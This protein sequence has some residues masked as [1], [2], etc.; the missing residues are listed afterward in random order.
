MRYS[1]YEQSSHGM[2]KMRSEL[3]AG[4]PAL[5]GYFRSRLLLLSVLLLLVVC[6][7]RATS[8][9]QETDTGEKI[10]IV[11]V[12]RA[13]VTGR[14]IHLGDIASIKSASGSLLEEARNAQ[15]C[16]ASEP[17]FSKTLH[18]GYIKSRLRQ[19][20][21]PD[22]YIS[23]SGA[24]QVI[25][26]TKATRLTPQKILSHAEVSL[27]FW[28]NTRCSIPGVSVHIQPV[29]EI[30]SVTLPYGE[31]TVEVQPVS[32]NS[33]GGI[34][35]LSFAISVDDRECEKRVILFKVEILKEVVIAVRNLDKNKAIESEDLRIALRNIGEHLDVFFQKDE[36]IGK[37]SR[38]PI[39]EGTV[40][41]GNMIEALPVV[42]Q[43]DLVTIVI[44][45]PAFRITAQGKAKEDGAPGQIIRVANISSMKEIPAQVVGEKLVKVAFLSGSM[46]L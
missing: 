16:R 12:E 9:L 23:W 8:G 4:M 41:T 27:K 14:E 17:G 31:V 2:M 1:Y 34:V 19:Q 25:V 45:S 28:I 35:P 7:P 5:P 43:G 39:P 36:L 29:N 18:V 24:Q 40:I 30:R 38:R 46:G 37:R 15:I 20:G 22:E 13:L 10:S 6:A 44:E 21:I 32:P 33:I 26:E 42:F 3:Q 11:M